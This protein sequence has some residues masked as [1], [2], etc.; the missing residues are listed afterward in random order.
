MTHTNTNKVNE[1]LLHKHTYLHTHMHLHTLN[2]YYKVPCPLSAKELKR[3][4][5]K[6][7]SHTTVQLADWGKFLYKDYKFVQAEW[8]QTSLWWPSMTIH[9]VWSAPLVSS[10]VA[11]LQKAIYQSF[12]F[13]APPVEQADL[14]LSTSNDDGTVTRMSTANETDFI[15]IFKSMPEKIWLHL[16]HDSLCLQWT[17]TSTDWSDYA[18]WFGGSFKRET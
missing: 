3:Q 1:I 5:L 18:C 8:E 13:F 9:G 2:H 7:I 4:I 6:S 10:G 16:S 11:C 17:T 12:I 14:R 15:F